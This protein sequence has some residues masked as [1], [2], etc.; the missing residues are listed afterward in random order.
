MTKPA[1]KD[2]VALHVV[3]G[4]WFFLS[5]WSLFSNLLRPLG[6]EARLLDQLF[7][8]FLSHFWSQLLQPLKCGEETAGSAV[9]LVLLVELEPVCGGHFQPLR[10]E[11]AQIQVSCLSILRIKAHVLWHLSSTR[12][13]V[14]L[15][16]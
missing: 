2:S 1:G 8:W 13:I 3:Y 11:Q 5:S 14:A 4:T 9:Y 6:C 15:F 12:E 10:C 16:F 7:T